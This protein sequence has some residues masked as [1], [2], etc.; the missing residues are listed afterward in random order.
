MMRRTPEKVLLALL[1]RLLGRWTGPPPP[2]NRILAVVVA[3]IGDCL[4]A[5][6]ALRALRKC[7]PDARIQPSLGGLHDEI[8]RVWTLPPGP[9]TVEI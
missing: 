4:L 1:R 9:I 7:Y 6:P 2:F 8:A 3:G 5:T